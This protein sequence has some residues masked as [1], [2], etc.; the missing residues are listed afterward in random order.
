VTE[1]PAGRVAPSRLAWFL[2]AA[3]AAGAASTGA[4][5]IFGRARD[6]MWAG[7]AQVGRVVGREWT[8]SV[9]A[10]AALGLVVH[11]G[12]MAALGAAMALLLGS[13]RIS[14]RLRAALLIV[15]AWEIA[16]RVPWL[17]VLRADM[18]SNLALAPR[19]GLVALVALAL[20]FAPRRQ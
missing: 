7:F 11:L 16:A 9:A 15:L 5:L 14:S 13:T 20:A 19:I 8:Q 18:A 6:G 1:T 4:L 12:Q 17:A 3:I 2:D 10:Q